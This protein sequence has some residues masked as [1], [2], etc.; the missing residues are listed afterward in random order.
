MPPAA[1]NGIG[2]D[3][4]QQKHV[5]QIS[6]RVYAEKKF[7]GTGIGLAIVKKAA[8]RMGG[9]VGLVSQLG[10]G[11]E[12]FVLLNRLGSLS[13]ILQT[14]LWYEVAQDPASKQSRNPFVWDAHMKNSTQLTIASLLSLLLLSIHFVDDIHR[15]ISPAG[16][17]RFKAWKWKAAFR[18]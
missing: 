13:A 11:S 4:R 2:I 9:S 3:R 14:T 5:F 18:S 16:A 8:E 17:E 1:G 15:G 7:E 10:S 6:G 12:F